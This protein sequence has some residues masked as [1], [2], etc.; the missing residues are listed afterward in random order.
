MT[1]THVQEGTPIA[2]YY[3]NPAVRARILEYCGGE[4]LAHPSCLFLSAAFPEQSAPHGWTLGRQCPVTDLDQL[5][6]RGAD[7]FRSILD[8]SS[9][10]LCFDVDY[11]NA[12]SAGQAFARPDEVF[13]KLEPTYW[14]V[15]NLLREYGM[16]MLALMTGRGYQFTGRIPLDAP[17]VDELTAQIPEE[18]DW[19]HTHADR[20][21]RWLPSRVTLRYARAYVATGLILEHFS[22]RVIRDAAGTSPIPVVL[23]GTNVGYIAD[24]REAVSLDLSFAGDPV[25]VRHM[26]VAFGAY[27]SHRFRPDI[28]GPEAAALDPL[29]TVPRGT[30]PLDVMLHVHRHLDGAARLATFS[31]ARIPDVTDGAQALVTDYARSSLARFHRAFYATRPHLPSAWANTYDRFDVSRLPPCVG[32][33]LAAPNDR[34][35]KP[36]YL[37]HVTRFLMGEGWAPRHVAGLIWSKY[38]KDFGWGERWLYL[39]PRSRA[40]FDVRVFGAMVATGLDRGIDF[41]CRSAQEKRMCPWTGCGHD[42]RVTRERL[43]E[44]MERP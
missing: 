29:V 13:E 19:Y 18:P 35:L 3:R 40:E 17:L 24:A 10:P 2:A 38:A 21:P 36:E 27:Q 41:N 15:R 37:Q 16:D 39:S 8:S 11:L 28:F 1:P 7:V 32:A 33:A 20:L 26:R 9:L 4:D 23:N 25:H 31:S 43:L 5:L 12:E 22:H 6:N 42:L 14:T 30:A 44:R 34:L